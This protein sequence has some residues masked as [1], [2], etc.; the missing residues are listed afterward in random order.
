M[1]N[2]RQFLGTLGRVLGSGSLLLP[3]GGKGA[4]SLANAAEA[5][6]VPVTAAPLPFSAEALR[7]RELRRGLRDCYLN[8]HTLGES[9]N[10]AWNQLMCRSYVPLE[11]R[12]VARKDVTWAH[13]VELAEIVWMDMAHRFD[14]EPGSQS[15]WQRRANNALVEA[16]LTL[17]G[18]ER[19]YWGVGQDQNPSVLP[20]KGVGNV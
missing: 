20:S 19:Y 9:Y 16:V 11:E 10:A 13:C 2:R 3:L 1:S 17:G 7:L 12:I 15:R 5:S 6:N 8:Q 4:L 14:F 18:G